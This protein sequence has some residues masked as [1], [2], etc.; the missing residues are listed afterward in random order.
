MTPIEV[1]RLELWQAAV[2]LGRDQKASIRSLEE[3]L[4]A[5]QER[6]RVERARRLEAGQVVSR[7]E[8]VIR[9]I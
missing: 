1:D 9:A 3:Q 7:P 2:M 8:R 4:Y 6:A 5:N